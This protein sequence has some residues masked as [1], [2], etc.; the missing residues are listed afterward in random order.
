MPSA[1]SE[2]NR[3]DV[4]RFR[5]KMRV[6]G[7]HQIHAWVKTDLRLALLCRAAKQQ[8][9]LSEVVSEALQRDVD[10]ETDTKNDQ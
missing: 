4:A 2:K 8:K 1:S 3:R 5:G 9:T 6:M 10:R 7:F